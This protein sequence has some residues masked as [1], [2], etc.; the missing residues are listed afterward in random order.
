MLI[1]WKKQYVLSSS[2]NQMETGH[3]NDT[4]CDGTESLVDNESLDDNF[5]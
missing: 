4:G 5:A 2:S 3:G 1:A